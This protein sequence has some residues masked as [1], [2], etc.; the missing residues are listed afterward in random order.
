MARLFN[1]L[2][3][4][5]QILAMIHYFRNRPEGYWFWII[6]FFGPVGA[7]I[8]FFAVVL[9][10]VRGGSIEGRVHAGMSERRRARQLAAKVNVGEALPYEFFEL[11]EIQYKQKRFDQA[12]RNLNQAVKLDPDNKDARYFLG[13]SL[14]HIGNYM[15]G[16][17]HL[18]QLVMKDP[19][20]KF[21]EAMH[22]L[23]RCYR[24][25]GESQAAVAAYKRVLAQSHFA[26]ARYN[27][28]ELLVKD[29]KSKE[30]LTELERLIRDAETT[31]LPAYQR[32]SEKAWVRKA[33]ALMATIRQK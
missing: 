30:A 2:W 11:G 33:K 9:S 20:F 19:R 14:S 8:Y 15:E 24:D 28:A 23:A 29:G 5:P 32:R 13:L 16:G 21:G 26:E 3:F 4:I 31:E 18:E 17:R 6:L 25:A 22:A 12:V 7:I 1:F 27:L 10:D